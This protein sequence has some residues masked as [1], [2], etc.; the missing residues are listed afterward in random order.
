MPLA[1]RDRRPTSQMPSAATRPYPAWIRPDRSPRRGPVTDRNIARFATGPPLVDLDVRQ[2]ELTKAVS[3]GSQLP[4]IR[5][6]EG[7]LTPSPADRVERPKDPSSGEP[8][9]PDLPGARTSRNM[10]W[11]EPPRRPRG[12][13]G[14]SRAIVSR[15]APAST[16]VGSAPA[17]GIF[18]PLGDAG[19]AR[20]Q[21]T[22][23][24]RHRSSNLFTRPGVRRPAFGRGRGF[25]GGPGDGW[26]NSAPDGPAPAPAGRG[27][28][29]DIA[30]PPRDP[31]DG[32]DPRRDG[33]RS[34]PVRA[35]PFPGRVVQGPLLEG[36]D[37]PGPSQARN[38][39]ADGEAGDGRRWMRHRFAR[40]RRRSEALP[41]AGG[42][43]DDVRHRG[44]RPR[45]GRGTGRRPP[46][47]NA[48]VVPGGAAQAPERDE[49]PPGRNAG[50]RPP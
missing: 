39:P 14:W 43:V 19:I 27:V 38:T 45:R 18:P 47:R 49:A 2:K 37:E 33:A 15:V 40:R 48:T 36:E 26:T 50:D 42:P 17:G 20:R 28:E 1:G 44:P 13:V 5:S 22:A 12:P 16:K 25:R 4:R 10:R 29:T 21:W 8:P 35:R 41:N 24:G 3:E 46:G 11:S 6:R 31:D 9:Q 23:P 30:P 34:G 32:S 7:P